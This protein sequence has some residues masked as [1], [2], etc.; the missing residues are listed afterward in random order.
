MRSP[1]TTEYIKRKRRDEVDEEPAGKVVAGDFLSIRDQIPICNVFI[2]SVE[3][4]KDV[5]NKQ[6][7][8]DV[9]QHNIIHYFERQ[10][11]WKDCQSV[12]KE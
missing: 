9:V 7:V 11:H 6:G 1:G 5:E 10:P 4:D 2:R 3:V 12:E 8:D